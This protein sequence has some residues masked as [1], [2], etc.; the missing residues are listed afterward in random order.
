LSFG[1]SCGLLWSSTSARAQDCDCD[2]RV[3]LGDTI[4]DGDELGYAPGDRVCVMAG[5]REFIRF[6]HL[7]GSADAPITI[8][9]CGGLVRI[10][11]TTR[12]YALVFEDDSHHFHLTGTGDASLTYGF[13]I[14]APDREP[15]PGVGLWLNGRSTNYEADHIEIHDTGFAGVSAKTDPYCDGSADQTSS[16][17]AT[18]TST[19]STCTTPAAKA[20]TSA[21]RRPTAKHSPATARPKCINPTS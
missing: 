16:P 8:L 19:T 5:E 11:N 9:N 20:S 2:H 18:C 15:Y 3:E 12:A 7:S 14:S 21:A 6:R 13:E 4:V 10:H 1:L 17:N